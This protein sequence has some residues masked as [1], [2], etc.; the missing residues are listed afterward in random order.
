M[1]KRILCNLLVVTTSTF[2]VLSTPVV[3]AQIRQ[4]LLNRVSDDDAA[5]PTL[6]GWQDKITADYSKHGNVEARFTA[7]YELPFSSLQRL[8]PGHR[9]FTI[10]WSQR[11]IPGREK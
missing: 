11:A 3:S 2:L 6:R 1:F 7:W 8:F 9:F 5:M 10:S 4:S